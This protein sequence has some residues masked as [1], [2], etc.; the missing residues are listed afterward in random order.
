MIERQIEIYRL[1]N[2]DPTALAKTLDDLGDLEPNTHLEVDEKNNALIVYGSLIDQATIRQLVQRL[3][4]NSRQFEVIRLRRLAA[5]YVA[6]TVQFMMVGEEEE[7]QQKKKQQQQ[8][9]LPWLPYLS[10]LE[11]PEDN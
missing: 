7:Q 8:F 4:G 10:C 11:E 5:D 6:G 3:D 9:S 2:L 1:N